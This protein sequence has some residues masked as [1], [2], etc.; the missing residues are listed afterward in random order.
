MIIENILNTGSE[1]LKK[2]K[3]QS[4]KLDSEILLSKA[5]NVSREYILINQKKEV[6]SKKVEKYYSLL[7]KR[8]KKEP[9]AYIIGYKEFWKKNFK[10]DRSVLIPRPDTEIIIEETLKLLPLKKSIKI[11]DIG[12][13]SGCILISI[14]YERKKC[15]GIGLD[16][17]KDA[18]K[19]AKINAK[20]QHVE[21]R[22]KFINSDI[23]KFNH[24]KYDLIL[25]NPPYL[26]NAEIKNLD[27]DVKF[28]EPKLS[29]N[30]GV[31]G[32]SEIK[33]VINKS[34][35]LL[36]K[37]GKLLLEIDHKQK[38]KVVNELKEKKFYINK[39]LKNY[40]QYDRTIICTKI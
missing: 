27:E 26:T 36:K 22:I 3:I 35:K 16:I 38:F 30:G 7:E 11:L 31:D 6:E 4:F 17:S 9:I 37:N 8:K 5:L 14:L 10:V 12:T 34:K 32:L 23:D 21:N 40:C 15:K 18:L 28:Y 25:S 33:K 13:G 39:I 20:L 2:N 29:L 24:D 19:T 1:T